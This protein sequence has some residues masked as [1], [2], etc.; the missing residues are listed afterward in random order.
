[1]TLVFVEEC[2]VWIGKFMVY[3]KCLLE[4][5]EGGLSKEEFLI[6]KTTVFIGDLFSPVL[7]LWL[8]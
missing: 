2:S 7:S 8:G 3:Y 6:E 4:A 5:Q 1:M